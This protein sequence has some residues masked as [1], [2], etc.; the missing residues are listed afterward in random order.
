MEAR[1]QLENYAYQIRNILNDEE[2]SK[3]LEADDKEALEA[4]VKETIEWIEENQMAEKDDFDEQYK[5]LE[6][7]AQPIFGKLYQGQGGMP[8][9]GAGGDEGGFGSHDEL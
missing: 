5:K 2:K 4:A 7:V 1:N 3:G 8:G 6:K 9:G